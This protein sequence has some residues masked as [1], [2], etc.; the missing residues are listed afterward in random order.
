[1]R[2][3]PEDHSRKDKPS[4]PDH[5]LVRPGTM[6]AILLG[7]LLFLLS[8]ALFLGHQHLETARR[9]L[10]VSD[11]TTASL[12]A[13]FLDEHERAV[14]GLLR[15]YATRP[16]FMEAIRRRDAR[17]ASRHLADLKKNHGIDLTFVTDPKGVLWLNYPFFP[18]SIGKDLS[19]RDWYRGISAHWNPYISEVFKL[20]VAGKPLA[21]AVAVP[22]VNETGKVIGILAN[23][24]RLEVLAKTIEKIP[25]SPGT[26][27]TILDRSGD[28]LF[29]SGYSHQETITKYPHLAMLEQA[30]KENRQ[31]IEDTRHGDRG[32]LYL[33]A[34]PVGETGWKVVVERRQRDIYRA[35]FIRLAEIGGAAL[36]LFV[37]TAVALAYLRRF[38]LYRKTEELLAA[39]RKTLE[40]EVRYRD[41]FQNAMEGIFQTAP[42][43]KGFL[44]AN[45]AMARIYGYDSAEELIA[46]V[47]DIAGQLYVNPNDRARILRR[48][49]KDGVLSAFEV[50]H[51]RKDGNTVWLSLHARAVRDESGKV[52][53]LEGM[54]E[55]ITHRKQAEEELRRLNEEL[56]GR[57]S[58]RTAQLEAANKELEA[59]SYSVSHDLRAPL[60]GIDGFSQA[61]LEDYQNK[62]L[63]ETGKDYLERVRA[64]V[65]RM[66]HLID[67][68]LKLSRVTRSEFH[69]KSVD[70]SGLVRNILNDRQ[71]N[72]PS[73]IVDAAIQEGLVVRGDP[74]LLQIAMENLIDNAWKFTGRS[75][76]PRIEF[77]AAVHSG[78]TAFFIRDNGVGFG[79]GYV[80]KLFV[81]FQRLHSTHEFP[82]TGIG[83]ATVKRIMDRHGGEVWAEGEIGKGATIF[84]T[85]PA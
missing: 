16:R 84:F 8:T 76:T 1:M 42:E 32:K 14:I 54:A 19:Y 26:T 9:S 28:I 80:H 49:V 46:A 82:G 45:P 66:G 37:L 5:W 48:I 13:N 63:D 35:E 59:F 51:R 64:G 36:L 67:D 39:Q 30:I 7:L 65:Q 57:V 56:E 24:H 15:S 6:A 75:S 60:R 4:P 61:L 41:L 50:Q 3:S 58:Q 17:E 44:S 18:E 40:S 53:R 77:G 62:P 23:S 2:N 70:L 83:L 10:L 29:S 68:M 74:D 34:I 12:L 55:D 22:V 69:P 78:K 11:K 21:V 73:R 52:V 79:M 72:D 47:T 85:L 43:G 25:F 20:I 33:S 81:P 71:L 38:F 27:V 31:Q